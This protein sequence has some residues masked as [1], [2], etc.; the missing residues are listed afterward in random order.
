M[1]V[2]D[3][4]TTLVKGSVMSGTNWLTGA[5]QGHQKCAVIRGTD[6]GINREKKEGRDGG[7]RRR[8]RQRAGRTQAWPFTVK[9][10]QDASSST[11]PSP[12]GNTFCYQAACSFH[13]TGFTW[14]IFYVLVAVAETDSL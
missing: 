9:D 5:S 12:L 6:R 8:G 10:T 11:S 13:A 3:L 1:S 2:I 14:M 4:V 7:R